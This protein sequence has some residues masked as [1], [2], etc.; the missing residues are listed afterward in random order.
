MGV[1]GSVDATLDAPA[2]NEVI[3]FANSMRSNLNE[4]ADNIRAICQNMSSD[5]SLVGGDGEVIKK[6]YETIASTIT[7]LEQSFEHIVTILNQKLEVIYQMNAGK[8][9]AASTEAAEHAKKNT[10]L[11]EKN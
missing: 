9:T 3:V 2:L 5:E 11:Y 1:K 10:A 7:T 4:H 6:N 8:N